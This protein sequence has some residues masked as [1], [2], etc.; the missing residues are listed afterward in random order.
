MAHFNRWAGLLYRKGWEADNL[1]EFLQGLNGGR[2]SFVSFLSTSTATT[3]IQITI[4][5]HLGNSVL[6]QL[7]FL[8]QFLV[9]NNL[10]SSNS[11]LRHVALLT[12]THSI[13]SSVL[14]S[15]ISVLFPAHNGP[16]HVMFLDLHQPLLTFHILL[17]T[18]AFA[19]L[20][21]CHISY[22]DLHKS[23]FFT[24]I[25]SQLKHHSNLDYLAINSTCIQK[26]SQ[27]SL[28]S[29]YSIITF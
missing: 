28:Y 10:F 1:S 14:I 7:V 25:I 8:L 13:L 26:P 16:S 18:F 22:P 29:H 2:V 15:L 4:I 19:V 6:T 12:L 24:L 27:P 17:Q 9:K 5:P 11:Q 3:L 20:P 23:S 21:L